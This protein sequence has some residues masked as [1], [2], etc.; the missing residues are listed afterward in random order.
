MTNKLAFPV[1]ILLAALLGAATVPA[2]ASGGADLRL[3]PAPIHRLDDESLQRGAR[4]F[5]NYC[6]G[7]H[8]AKHVRYNSLT[9]I[10]LTEDQIR[11]NL[12]LGDARIGDPMVSAMPEASA[13]AWF[14]APP[15]DLSLIARVR[16][17]DWLYNYLL[18]FYR[19]EKSASGWNNLVFHNVGM[20]HVLWQ[21]QGQ[22]KLVETEFDE[23][24]KALA[25]AIGVKG[26]SAL[27]PAG[28]GKWVVR[29]VAASSEGALNQLQYEAFAADLVNFLDHMGTPHRN[30]SITLGIIVLLFLGVLFT[31]VYLLKR[32]YWKEVH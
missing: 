19:D 16:G 27:E 9:Q 5:V 20:P 31:L 8:S 7:C 32:N 15:P 29:T 4:N 11:N 30:Q 17:T 25:A 12:I 22:R 26:L 14:A 21:L 3:V 18:G 13:R 28:G 2:Q 24:E 10:G 6:L 1:A 23:H